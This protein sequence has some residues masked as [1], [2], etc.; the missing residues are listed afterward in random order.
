MEKQEAIGYIRVS[1]ELQ[2][3]SLQV[4]EQRIRDYC[5]FNKLILTELLIDENVSGGTEIFKRPEGRKLKVLTPK[6]I[7]AVKPDRLF[8]STKD[9]LITTDEWDKQ[10]VILHF[11][12]V[13]GSSLSTKTAIGKLMFTTIIAFAELERS[14]ASERTRAVLGHKRR[15]GRTY[16]KQVY[17]YDNVDGKLVPNPAEKEIIRWITELRTEGKNNNQIAT[18]LNAQGIKTKT[19]GEFKGSTI[20]GIL[21]RLI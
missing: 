21:K 20:A 13:G 11:A 16:C 3:N 4:Q 9:A 6:N 19:G 7:V 2:D 5:N 10:G 1:T 14:L 15:A 8:R 12:D 18:V 17:G